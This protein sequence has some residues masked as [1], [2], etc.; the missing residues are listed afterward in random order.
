MVRRRPAH[1]ARASAQHRCLHRPSLVSSL[2]VC[3][4]SSSCCRAVP[5][6]DTGPADGLLVA[7]QPGGGICRPHVVGRGETLW[8]T[9][10]GFIFSR[11]LCLLAAPLPPGLQSSGT[12]RSVTSRW[13]EGGGVAGR[14]FILSSSESQG[15]RMKTLSRSC[16]D[17]G[18]SVRPCLKAESHDSH[19]PGPG[20][21]D[22][23]G[24][25]W[26]PGV[27]CTWHTQP[28]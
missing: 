9:Y 4:G 20:G 21:Q 10:W 8:T 28:Q 13:R 14:R 2:C 16:R 1:G 5:P 7:L 3:P 18:T 26:E 27:Q 25:G 15:L 22:G 6:R 23:A 11:A 12:F 19:P 17:L 24:A